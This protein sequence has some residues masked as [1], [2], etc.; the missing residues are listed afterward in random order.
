MVEHAPLLGVIPD[1]LSLEIVGHTLEGVKIN[2]H[3]PAA[4]LL[5]PFACFHVDILVT[6]QSTDRT[7]RYG[8]STVLSLAT[9]ATN[10]PSLGT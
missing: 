9:G 1:L 6:V 10:L 3:S 2:G 4:N 7:A 5:M 8:L